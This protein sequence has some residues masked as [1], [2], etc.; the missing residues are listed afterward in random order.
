VVGTAYAATFREKPYRVRGKNYWMSSISG[1][2]A[3]GLRSSSSVVRRGSHRRFDSGIGISIRGKDGSE[4]FGKSGL[5]IY[6]DGSNGDAE[7]AARR[8][9]GNPLLD[10]ANSFV[11]TDRRPRGVR[12][13]LLEEQDDDITPAPPTYDEAEAAAAVRRFGVGRG[14]F[15][16]IFE[17]ERETRERDS[18]GAG[19]YNEKS[20]NAHRFNQKAAE[21]DGAFVGNG[22]GKKGGWWKR[23]GF[24]SRFSL[25]LN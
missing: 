20:S 15:G 2:S 17:R 19:E 7:A 25:G 24:K 23:K 1:P 3:Y 16:G 11:N 8:A 10:S 14:M 13:R 12:N 9:L 18:R 5:T 21:D 4:K 6:E 22:N